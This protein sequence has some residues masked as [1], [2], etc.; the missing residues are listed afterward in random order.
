MS[1]TTSCSRSSDAHCPRLPSTGSLPNLWRSRA[2]NLPRGAMIRFVLGA[3]LRDPEVFPDPDRFDHTR[4]KESSA[5]LAF[6]VGTHNCAGQAIA[7]AVL[8]AVLDVIVERFTTVELVGRSR[9]VTLR[10]TPQLRT[11]RRSDCHD[12]RHNHPNPL[13]LHRRRLHRERR[14]PGR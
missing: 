10:P 4:P 13:R 1:A 11:P 8:R 3:A 9:V 12:H 2:S 5:V 7:R 6:G 14:L